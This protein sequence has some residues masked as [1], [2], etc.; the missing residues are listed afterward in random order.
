MFRFE[1]AEHLYA[2]GLVPIM[3]AFFA[4]AWIARKKALR[5][6]GNLALI[7]RL[8]PMASSGKHML[9]F[10]L[11]AVGLLLLIIGWANPQW[12]TKREK[13]TRKS[14]DVFMALDISQSMMAE[15]ISPS[16]LERAK[17]FTQNL[18]TALRGERLGTI[19]F[20]GNAY[21]QVP[22]TTDYAA[23]NLFI[24]SANTKM[25][26][27][28]G[29]AI[30]DAIDLAARSFEEE[31]KNHKALVV[32]TDGE[33]HDDEALARAREANENGLLI[34]TVGVGTPEGSFIPTYIGGRLDYKR[35]Q[36]GNPVKSKLNEEML[37]DLAD[38]G[39]GDYFNLLSGSEA[40]AEAL[41]Q[42]IESMEKRELEQRVFS[43]Y[44]SYFQYFIGAGLLLLLLEFLLSYKKNRY[45]E[46]KDLFGVK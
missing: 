12:G 40:V 14:V 1:F 19:I 41:K 2:L 35:D 3:V 33:N 44:E 39:D 38:A 45:F 20:A 15:D 13:V 36:T 9:K 24:K 30:V 29:T 7:E 22:L 6:F 42:R 25:A 43:R 34:F 26:P 32:I 28:Q 37:K 8:M 17:R 31:N 21:L 46:G 11:L 16:R 18:I 5:R 27:T 10:V 4:T 23:A